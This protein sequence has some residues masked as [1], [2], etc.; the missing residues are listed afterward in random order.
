MPRLRRDTGDTD[1][2]LYECVRPATGWTLPPDCVLFLV[3]R[4]EWWLAIHAPTGS[5]LEEVLGMEEGRVAFKSNSN[6]LEPGEHNWQAAPYH[7]GCR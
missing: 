2:P 4:G 7:L 5:L 6:I 1:T 3:R